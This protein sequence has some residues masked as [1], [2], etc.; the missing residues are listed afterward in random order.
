MQI[1]NEQALTS[2]VASIE[3][4]RSGKFD[5]SLRMGQ[6]AVKMV[7]DELLHRN[8]G[9]SVKIDRARNGLPLKNRKFG[10]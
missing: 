5:E 10:R 6:L 3:L 2:M 9:H 8:M 4:E 7:N 1:E